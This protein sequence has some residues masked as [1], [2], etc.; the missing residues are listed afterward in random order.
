M[1]LRAGFSGVREWIHSAPNQA[2]CAPAYYLDGLAS[3]VKGPH[4]ESRYFR[5]QVGRCVLSLAPRAQTSR[6]VHS[7]RCSA[8]AANDRVLRARARTPHSNARSSALALIT[9]KLAA[10]HRTLRALARTPRSYA[11]FSASELSSTP[12][13]AGNSCAARVRSHSALTPSC[14]SRSL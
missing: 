4:P 3:A 10:A 13:T 11:L 1:V 5:Q 2:T 8:L 6:P 12:S 14:C 7:H 9:P